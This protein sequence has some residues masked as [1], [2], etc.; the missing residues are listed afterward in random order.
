MD[1]LIKTKRSI[2]LS[3]YV[4]IEDAVLEQRLISL[5]LGRQ[6]GHTKYIKD[7]AT[8]DDLVLLNSKDNITRFMEE[9]PRTN[10][11]ILSE[12]GVIGDFDETKTY[13]NIWIDV[14]SLPSHKIPNIIERSDI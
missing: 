13:N 12:R 6:I 9:N 5:N 4:N 1:S 7:N 8:E 14:T 10:Y 11:G 2:L 3:S